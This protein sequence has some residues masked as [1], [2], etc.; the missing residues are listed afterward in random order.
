MSDDTQKRVILSRDPSRKTKGEARKDA[1]RRWPLYAA[2]AIALVTLV[3]W[4]DGGEEPIRPIAEK[5]TLSDATS[6]PVPV[7]RHG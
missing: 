7:E 4:I 1:L 3:A 6:V 2:G 5:V